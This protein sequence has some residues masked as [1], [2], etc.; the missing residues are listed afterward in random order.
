MKNLMKWRNEQLRSPRLHL[1]MFLHYNAHIHQRN[2]EATFHQFTAPH[3]H[4]MQAD[5][6]VEIAPGTFVN[7][8]AMKARVQ[9]PN[10]ENTDGPEKSRHA[11]AH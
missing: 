5:G 8:E 6:K 11:E 2:R 3:V 10:A 7:I 9:V 1:S 4:T